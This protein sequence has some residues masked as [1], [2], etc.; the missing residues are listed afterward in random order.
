VKY[1]WFPCIGCLPENKKDLATG[2]EPYVKERGIVPKLFHKRNVSS[3]GILPLIAVS[4]RDSTCTIFCDIS[5]F[6]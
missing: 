5:C 3:P 2:K 1:K 4:I 6:A